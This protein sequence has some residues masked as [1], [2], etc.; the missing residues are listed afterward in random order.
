MINNAPPEPLLV[1]PAQCRAA[2]ALLAWSQR[3][4]AEKAGVATSTVADFERGY[5]TPADASASAIVKALM[6][7][8][9]T[10]TATGAE[11]QAQAQHVPGAQVAPGEPFRWVTSTDLANWGASRV[12][13][14]TS[15]ELISRLIIAS[16]GSEAQLLF[17]AGDSVA[18]PGYDGQCDVCNGTTEVPAGRS[19][20]EIGT[21][22]EKLRAKADGD[23]EKRTRAMS[24]EERKNCT[25]IF[26][27]L[28]RWPSKAKWAALKR[29]AGE[30]RDVRVYDADILIHWLEMYPVVGHWLAS[31]LGK[32]PLGL[33]RLEE[34]WEEWSLSTQIPTNPELVLAGRDEEAAR[35]LL[36]LRGSP[37]LLS[38]QADSAA[39]ARAFLF[40]TISALP[41]R[42]RDA[43]LSR[44][45][46]ASSE[47]A[48]ALR[49]SMSGLIIVLE[50]PDPGLAASIVKRHHVYLPVGANATAEA[51][52]TRLTRPFSD[53]VELALREMG[54][55]GASAR[56]YAK[57]SGRS[58]TIIRR[59]M[60][61]AAGV[62]PPFWSQGHVVKH[63]VVAFLIGAWEGNREGD[64]AVLRRLAGDTYSEAEA[65]LVRLA[66]PPD[67][68]LWK[69]SDTWKIASP[70]DAWFIL[71]SHLSPSIF[72]EFTKIAVEVLAEAD[73]LAEMAT[74]DRWLAASRG[75]SPK[76]SQLLRAGI[77]ETLALL[78]VYGKQ[79]TGVA[80]ILFKVQAIIRSL[81]I[82]ADRQRW[83]ALEP[84]L[85]TLAEAAPEVFLDAVE[86]SLAEN[87]PPVMGLF[88]HD[89]DTM[90]GAH[91]STLLWALECL[92]WS[93]EYIDQ[94]ARCLATLNWLDPGGRY[95]NRPGNSLRTIFLLW[96]PQT[97]A[98]LDQRLRIIDHLREN[99]PQT[100]WWLM[101][102]LI[103]RGHD[104]TS[105][106]PLP[107]WRD[108]ADDAPSGM[109]YE[110]I[111]RGADCLVER[112]QKDVNCD[113][114]RWCDV[115]D[116]VDRFSLERVKSTIS[117]LREQ[118]MT[119]NDDGARDQLRHR[120]RKLIH[121]HR[122]FD[123]ADWALPADVINSFEAVHDLLVPE[124][125]SKR[126][127]WLFENAWQAITLRPKS[128]DWQ[129]DAR[130][131]NLERVAAIEEIAD[132]LGHEFLDRIC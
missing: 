78:S 130:V 121:H 88:G 73:P 32:R 104:S 47:Q 98:N 34:D 10:L 27:T 14:D 65:T 36:W 124:N 41:P 70:R 18:M 93:G 81:L 132:R 3:E 75:I 58:A 80:D 61:A 35:A 54:M 99:E 95:A 86:E 82:G 108:F 51:A 11:D 44:A 107:R 19:F 90:S 30:W 45:F 129:E 71:A 31:L 116:H 28:Q 66:S 122:Q 40:A 5:R 125:P 53:D 128:N 109:T 38:Y 117:L 17:P 9:I 4:L 2:R 110:E 100:A 6:E 13:Q 29:A 15:P 25:F 89:T 113:V 26:V 22:K 39:E 55:D 102:A 114:G 96:S 49:S 77:A 8:G 46:V 106:T 127:A 67:S 74:T 69:V 94:A 21:Q 76:Y 12:G 16:V 56:R 83:L 123:K 7:A 43:Y 72:E 120:L 42:H 20:W 23:Y 131:A 60:P 24:A 103:P 105:P 63:A 85:Q 33:R 97:T 91:H 64:R 84:V 52:T 79:A 1:T 118:V 68:L 92:A 62:A 50:Q 101:L 57:D 115:L 87:N 59:L 111:F 112:I 37:S 119:W 48:R 126:L